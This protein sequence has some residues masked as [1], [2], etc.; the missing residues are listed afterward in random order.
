MRQLPTPDNPTPGETLQG[1]ALRLLSFV[2]T[3]GITATLNDRQLELADHFYPLAIANPDLLPATR[4]QFTASRRQ[5]MSALAYRKNLTST[6][7]EPDPQ[8]AG[9]EKPA[10]GPMAPLRPSPPPQTPPRMAV[11]LAF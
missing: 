10:A 7:A 5:I 1:Y 4:E 11:D 9:R 8:P 2:V 6:P 3:T